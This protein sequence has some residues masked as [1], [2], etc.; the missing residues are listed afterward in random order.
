[1]ADEAEVQLRADHV[2]LSGPTYWVSL[3]YLWYISNQSV[4]PH[5][6]WAHFFA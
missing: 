4:P 1:M 5:F 2:F 6:G 3:V